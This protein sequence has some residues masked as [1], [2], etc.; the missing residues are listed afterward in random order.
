MDSILSLNEI[1]SLD[2]SNPKN[3]D[4]ICPVCNRVYIFEN[5]HNK[6][7]VVY[8]VEKENNIIKSEIELCNWK[9]ENYKEDEPKMINML[10]ILMGDIVV[11]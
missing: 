7:K 6:A 9:Q 4:L 2:I 3:K 10:L 5:G 8:K 11:M 1:D